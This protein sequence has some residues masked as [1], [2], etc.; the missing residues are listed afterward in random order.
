MCPKECPTGPIYNSQFGVMGCVMKVAIIGPKDNRIPIADAALPCPPNPDP[1][2][3]CGIPQDQIDSIL[4]AG[5]RFKCT[6][7]EP[8]ML[9]AWFLDDGATDPLKSYTNAHSVINSSTHS[10]RSGWKNCSMSRMSALGDKIQIAED[11]ELGSFTPAKVGFRLDRAR[12]GLRSKPDVKP[13]KIDIAKVKSL[14]G[15]GKVYLVSLNRPK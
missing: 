11:I 6:G 12:I 1:N 9:N 15:G 3:A 8:G 14:K 5:A 10:I 13:M 4:A 7:K 2:L